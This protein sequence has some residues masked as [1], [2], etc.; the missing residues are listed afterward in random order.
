MKRKE[1]PRKAQRHST[2]GNQVFKAKPSL[3]PTVDHRQEEM[4]FSKELETPG[5]DAATVPGK[6]TVREL[7]DGKKV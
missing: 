2:K 3:S 6:E 4:G 7:R 1:V 5:H